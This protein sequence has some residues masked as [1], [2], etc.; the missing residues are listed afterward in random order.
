VTLG[1]YG[2][3]LAQLDLAD[4][5]EQ[6]LDAAEASVQ[7]IGGPHQL[8]PIHVHRGHVD[9]A[10]AR[11]HQRAAEDAEA[12]RRFQTAEGRM[13][14]TTDADAP[15][16]DLRF[17][18]RILERALRSFASRIAPAESE[19]AAHRDA[20]IV[21]VDGRWFVLPNGSRVEIE[22]RYALRRVL[23]TLVQHRIDAPGRAVP[24][25]VIVRGGWPGERM[26]ADAAENRAKVA[27][28]R[29]RKLGI[30]ALLQSVESGHRLDPDVPVVLERDART[31]NGL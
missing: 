17:A 28:T 21:A 26:R 30:A 15:T 1:P 29:L 27:L 9:L 11:A 31:C 23:L 18:R 4:L 5:G 3:V 13:L 12:F 14:V 20:L 6:M 2:A 25:D 24:L 8:P 22:K 10:R 19:H 7:A 16:D